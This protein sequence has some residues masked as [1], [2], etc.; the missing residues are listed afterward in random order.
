MAVRVLLAVA[1]NVR[2]VLVLVIDRVNWGAGYGYA[3]LGTG[4]GDLLVV[5]VLLGVSVL[6]DVLVDVGVRERVGDR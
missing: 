2:G 1:V 5:G 4:D 3:P 6:V